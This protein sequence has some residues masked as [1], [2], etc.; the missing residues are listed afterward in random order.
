MNRCVVSYINCFAA[1]IFF[2]TCILHMMPEVSEKVAEAFTNPELSEYPLAE[3]IYALGQ[4][5]A[6]GSPVQPKILFNRK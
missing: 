1:G 6:L 5:W 3:L 4:G 2:G